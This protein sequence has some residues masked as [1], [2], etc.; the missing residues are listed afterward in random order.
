MVYNHRNHPTFTPEYTFR[1]VSGDETYAPIPVV[2]IGASPDKPCFG[3]GNIVGAVESP[4][5]GA[6]PVVEVEDILDGAPYTIPGSKCWWAPIT[7]G[8][9]E[10][11]A[12]GTIGTES[13]RLY[14]ETISAHD[15]EQ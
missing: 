11:L 2:V 10:A 6:D 4:Y 8:N 14:L 12:D 13:I 9:A 1:T 15:T 5:G 7:P 3:A